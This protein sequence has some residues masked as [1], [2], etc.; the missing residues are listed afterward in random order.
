MRQ[1]EHDKWI[2]ISE[3][4]SHNK[5]RRNI[6]TLWDRNQELI[7][8]RIRYQWGYKEFSEDEIHT[9]CG[10][11]EVNSFE[12]GT[13]G[14]RARA[15][16]PE[17][18]L[19]CHD[20][21]PN[22]THTDDTLTHK[23][24]L[25]TTIPLKKGS[26]ITLSY[27][28]TLQGTLKRRDHLHESKFFWCTCNRC[29]DPTELGTHA[30]TLLCPKCT[31]G[32]ILSTDSLNQDADWKCKKCCYAV[33]GK[34]ILILLDRL[35]DEL[36]VLDPNSIKDYEEYLKRYANVLHQNHYLMLSAKHSL[37][38]LIG[39][40][41]GFL[42]NELNLSQLQRKEQYCRDLLAVV[43]VFEPGMSRLRGIICYEMHAAMMMIITR[44]FENRTINSNQLRSRLKEIVKLLHESN[45]I[46]KIEP[47]GSP[48]YSMSLAAQ[49]ALKKMGNI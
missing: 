17:A 33:S 29:K 18:Y 2:K 26:T 39:R 8:D 38:Q 31:N 30:S 48:E 4:E 20:C 36:E 6:P 49:D 11:L 45:D 32:F 10:I 1:A 28:Y 47:I 13:N 22:T 15:L 16:F 14:C 3:M 7:V 9:I 5:I 12:V 41:D 21:Q 35:F 25:R 24:H 34:S 42:I 43:N 19:I 44:E 23:L 46:L 37:C 40:S 27:S